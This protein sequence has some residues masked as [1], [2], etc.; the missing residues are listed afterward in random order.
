MRK[1][2]LLVFSVFFQLTFLQAQ[3]GSWS[4]KT[5]G[6]GVCRDVIFSDT[7]YGWAVADSGKIMRSTNGGVTWT[8]QTSPTIRNL[9]SV[10]FLDR[11]TGLAAGAAGT[12]L[13]TTNGGV[14][15]VS[16]PTS[17]KVPWKRIYFDD[18]QNGWLLSDTV[19]SKIHHSTDGGLTWSQVGPQLFPGFQ[20]ADMSFSSGTNGWVAGDSILL[21]SSDGVNWTN[22]NNG[23]FTY[24]FG[25]SFPSDTTG[26]LLHV[27]SNG[28]T[29]V[30][31]LY[32][33]TDAG[34]NWNT[35][36]VTFTGMILSSVTFLSPNEGWIAGD[37]LHPSSYFLAGGVIYH[38]TD[39]GVHWLRELFLDSVTI[40]RIH[41]TDQTHGWFAGYSY[42]HG[43][44]TQTIGKYSGTVTGVHDGGSSLPLYFALDQNYPNPFNPS[45]IIRFSL[46]KEEHVRLEVLDLEGKVVRVLVDGVRPPGE[47]SETFSGGTFSSGIYFYRLTDGSSSVTKKMIFLR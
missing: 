32:T 34:Q 26:Y 27:Y 9:Y 28:S 18:V 8:N 23:V 33:T 29:D 20:V 17:D 24:L 31:I 5:L 46:S 2:T 38:T 4:V 44:N 11:N 12:F 21:H 13:K 14:S 41:F 47:Y 45:T 6:S 7:S 22:M 30:S 37:S 35:L 19:T 43:T 1:S 3:S 36:P 39:A 42:T 16:H 25:V 10:F 40:N 15:W